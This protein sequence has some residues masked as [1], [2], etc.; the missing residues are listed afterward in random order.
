M[1]VLEAVREK[2]MKEEEEKKVHASDFEF[3]WLHFKII[4]QAC[5][6]C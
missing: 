4:D 3:F 1:K 5:R 6:K 2:E